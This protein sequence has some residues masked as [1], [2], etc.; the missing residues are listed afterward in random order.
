MRGTV[1]GLVL[2]LSVV[3]GRPASAQTKPDPI[4]FQLAGE[5]MAAIG[6][7]RNVESNL[8]ALFNGLQNNL[9]AVGKGK[10]L[11][12]SSASL[13]DMRREVVALAPDL[14]AIQTQIYASNFSELELRDYL[15]FVR[16]P[17]GQ[18]VAA[19]TASLMTQTIEAQ[20]PLLRRA[21]PGIMGRAMERVCDERKCTPEQRQ[22]LV[23][24]I[25]KMYGDP[26]APA[27][28]PP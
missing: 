25:R 26:A 13:S 15:A 8:D 28:P 23:E 16:S 3:G 12:V 27:S 11:E 7:A 19:K 22:Q 20:R 5:L 17:S 10:Q 9:F 6:G 1:L 14:V 21:M 24:E 2:L 18:A 4:Q